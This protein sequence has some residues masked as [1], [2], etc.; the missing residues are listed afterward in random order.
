ERH[1]LAE[2]R[3]GGVPI[4]ITGCV[5]TGGCGVA[6]GARVDL[7]HADQH[8]RYDHSGARL[9]GHQ[10]T[11]ASGSFAFTTIVPGHVARRT[12]HVRIRITGADG[13]LLTTQLFFPGDPRN[14]ADR[15]Y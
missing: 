2:P 15:L 11:D 12:R 7:W 8:G 1:S 5:R 9:R 10:F 4:T 6:A 14:A 13:S 3:S